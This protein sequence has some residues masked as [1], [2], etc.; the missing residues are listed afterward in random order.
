MLINRKALI[1]ALAAAQGFVGGPKDRPSL[2]RICIRRGD[3]PEHVYVEATNNRTALRVYLEVDPACAFIGPVFVQRNEAGVAASTLRSSVELNDVLLRAAPARDGTAD[4]SLWLDGYD[5]GPLMCGNPPAERMPSLDA[6]MQRHS[7]A[8]TGAQVPTSAVGL[9][10]VAK[11]AAALRYLTDKGTPRDTC[12]MSLSALGG[13]FWE[14][15]HPIAG[16]CKV[17]AIATP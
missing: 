14:L 4:L 5:F 10:N 16:V 13:V 9:A 12:S 6:I 3:Q 2:S 1:A 7:V 8:R 15:N 11:A 17:A